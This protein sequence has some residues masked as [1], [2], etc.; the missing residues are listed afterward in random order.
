MPSTR[1]NTFH[2]SVKRLL[3]N[4]PIAIAAIVLI[5][6]FSYRASAY[7]LLGGTSAGFL[8]FT[9]LFIL[10]AR[11]KFSL[12]STSALIAYIWLLSLIKKIFWKEKLFFSDFEVLLDPNNFET[13]AHY[14]LPAAVVL[15]VTILLGFLL[16]R[17]FKAET[18]TVLNFSKRTLIG[19]PVMAVCAGL[20]VFSVVKGQAAWL[21]SMP[22]GSNVVANLIMSAKLQYNSPA[23]VMH[24]DEVFPVETENA[25]DKTQALPDVVVLL[26][27]STTNPLF[28]KG[29]DASTLPDMSMF[30]SPTATVQGPLRVHTYGGATWK[31]EFSMWTGLSCDDFAPLV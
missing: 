10:S 8:F 14:P 21:N 24:S 3:Q 25:I 17:A 30:D 13:V 27:E 31:S 28:F 29:L 7:T 18:P 19:L 26:Q 22:K 16:V 12:L 5:L 1:H 6:T 20:T 15:F 4:L 23:A 11:L 2:F 9:L